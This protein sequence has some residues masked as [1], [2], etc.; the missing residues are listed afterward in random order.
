MPKQQPSHTPVMRQ[1]L[2]LKAQQPDALLF[3]RMG[4]FYELFYDDAKRAAKLLDLTLTER[5]RSGGKPIPM[6]GVPVVSVDSYL[7]R[8]ARMG[9]SVAICE[10]VGEAPAGRGLMERKLS[11][12]V[13]PGTLTEDALLDAGRDMLLLALRPGEP[14]GLA[15]LDLS[16]GRMTVAEPGGEE[17]LQAELER[18]RP[19]ELL[20]PES[21]AP[22][23][24]PGARIRPLADWH[25]DAETAQRLLCR[26]FEV[27][28]LSGF[29]CA[30][31]GPALGAAGAL[32]Y[33]AGET[34]QSALPH[35]TQMRRERRSDQ[36]FLDAATRRNLELERSLSG[37]ARL[38]L[39]SSMDATVSAMGRRSLGRLLRAPLRDRAA[40]GARHRTVA[41]L[42]DD[43]LRP[44]VRA[45]LRGIADIERIVARI[46]LGSA[47]PR[48]L[49]GLG[50]SPARLPGLRARLAD[51][52]A[53]EL[54]AYAE[55]LQHDEALAE[56]LRR[57]IVEGPPASLRDG[58]VIAQGY[59]AEL[60]ELRALSQNAHALL[61]QMEER[62]RAATGIA[63]LKVAY[64][65]VHG[66]YIEVPRSQAARVPERY[67]RR[68]T[69]KN[70]ERFLTPELKAFEDQVLGAQARALERERRL[71]RE[72]LAALQPAIAPL[73]RCA[74]A[75]GELD[76]LAGFAERAVARGYCAPE[77]SDAP[78][79]EI[80]QGR[81]PVLETLGDEPF[82]PNDIRLG[83]GRRLQIITG[84][85]MGGKS[86]Y[87][88][89]CALIVLMACVGSYVPAA[90]ARI[91]PIDRIFTRIGASDDLGSG[92]ST[93]MVEMTETASIL[94]HA[95]EHS[96]VL[97]DEVGRGTSTFDG[98]ALAL[99][100]AE[101]L[102]ARSRA[103]TLFATHY[104]ELTQ[105]AESHDGIVNVH[106]DAEAQGAG[107]VFLHAVREGPASQSYG[108]QVA[109]LAGVLPEVLARA[110]EQLRALE[111]QAAAEQSRTI[112]QRDL[113]APPAAA[114]SAA[115]ARLR[116][117]DPDRLSPREAQA[118][119][120][121]LKQLCA[122]GD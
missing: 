54:R 100:C 108:L 83:P 121:E 28:D 113:F 69:L 105:L 5:G 85:N 76:V 47:A 2:D 50:E 67:R 109:R 107:I 38:C 53:S 33:Y 23:P 18:L 104:F 110:A 96:L 27:R 106:L 117:L 4:D 29:D 58:G 9:E 56:L 6:A 30:D 65:R 73:Q 40:I 15:H 79:I 24:C 68:Q 55:R 95:T 99:A 84:P 66:Y 120:Y 92:R 43:A 102:A 122:P 75:L 7:A 119:L 114:E 64:N 44:D 111:N 19:A 11:R 21:E 36:L 88:R 57:A 62:E 8:L 77:M 22:P 25:F 80:E 103:W 35:I 42:T 52:G 20:H 87:M 3:Y 12:I 112:P 63:Q 41:H 17:E 32:L 101:H 46:A 13:T 71:Y 34:Q 70:A 118:A 60:D 90:R 115:E 16:S 89:Q 45:P 74:A 116:A 91:G 86:T 48:G 49:A 59:D 61:R 51:S 10:Q 94:R 26:Q 37:D 1:Y 93:F 97:M 78:G 14:A 72:L 81:H 31:L 98:L 82:V 39:Q